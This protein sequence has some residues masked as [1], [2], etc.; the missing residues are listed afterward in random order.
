MELL[1]SCSLEKS[2]T[3]NGKL[4]LPNEDKKSPDKVFLNVVVMDESGDVVFPSLSGNEKCVTFVGTKA[5][6]CPTGMEGNVFNQYELEDLVN[7]R[8]K[9]VMNVV[10]LVQLPKDF[11]DMRML[12]GFCSKYPSVRFIGGN[13][14]RVDGVRIGRYDKGKDKMSPVMCDMYDT[15]V[16]VDLD[17]LSGLQEIVN[18]TRVKAEKVGKEKKEKIKKEPREKKVPKRVE[19]F[20]NMFGLAEVEF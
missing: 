20:N 18:K 15:F 16:E 5:T 6:Y 10:D 7:G 4:A 11:C 8:I 2:K 12:K 9:P 1:A 14:L 3:F 13:L 17:D 19:A